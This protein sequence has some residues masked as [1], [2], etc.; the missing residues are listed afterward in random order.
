MW[1]PTLDSNVLA[2]DR[3]LWAGPVAGA[4][5]RVAVV[6]AM[7]MVVAID[8]D[9]DPRVIRVGG[10]GPLV[11]TI[12]TR[13]RLVARPQPMSCWPLPPPSI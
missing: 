6:L 13:D 8:L 10:L 2:E 1:S 7:L 5:A 4:V 3:G 11:E 9:L 12:L